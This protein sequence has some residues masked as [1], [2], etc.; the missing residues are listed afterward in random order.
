LDKF[1]RKELKADK[2]AEEVSHSIEFFTTHR[3]QSII[4][5]AAALALILAIAG[6]YYYRQSQHKARQEALAQA[7]RVHEAVVG[8]GNPD[9]PRASFPTREAKDLAQR[10]AFLLVTTRY[11]SSNEGA[12][13]HFHLG[14]LASEKGNLAEA[15]KH[16]REAA[17]RGDKVIASTANYSLAQVLVGM[18][19]YQ[20]AEKLL[21]DL[22]ANPTILVSKEQA[23]IE[24]ARLIARTKPAEARKML[25]PMQQDKNQVVVR[26]AAAA[27]G[28]L[29]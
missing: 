13:A 14:H 19:K 11:P 6:G 29:P 2:F 24:L 3:R 12:T 21:R 1:T 20:D 4:Y 16:F 8:P 17:K 9:D 7:L 22:I 26:N 18:H 27:L 25:E 15:E 5:G 28:E 10:Q 23:T